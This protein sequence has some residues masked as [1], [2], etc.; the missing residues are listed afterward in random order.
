METTGKLMGITMDFRTRKL[1]VTFQI[2]TEPVEELNELQKCGFLDI[3]AKKHRKRR[4]LDANSYFHALVGKIAD[5]MDIS[6]ST[7]RAIR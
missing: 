7:L 3:V 2:D 5:K 6:P 1:N 4:S